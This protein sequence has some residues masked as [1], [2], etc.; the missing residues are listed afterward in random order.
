[1]D[2]CV[3]SVFRDPE[4]SQYLLQLFAI[5]TVVHDIISDHFF[6]INIKSI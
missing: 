3:D 6:I 5:P 4:Q 1:M 2:A